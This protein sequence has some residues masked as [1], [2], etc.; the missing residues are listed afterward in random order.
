MEA[1]LAS[2]PVCQ[3]ACQIRI[4][5]R[6][7]LEKGLRA[8]GIGRPSQK[9]IRRRRFLLLRAFEYEICLVN[10]KLFSEGNNIF[11]CCEA[12]MIINLPTS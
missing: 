3:L 12:E 5:L 10:Q 2:L 7:E 8:D 9:N 6:Q 11:G 1:W 4:F